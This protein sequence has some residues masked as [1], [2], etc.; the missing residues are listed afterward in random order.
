MT[1]SFQKWNQTHLSVPHLCQREPDQVLSDLLPCQSQKCFS[2]EVLTECEGKIKRIMSLRYP[3]QTTR[4][5]KLPINATKKGSMWPRKEEGKYLSTS[6]NFIISPSTT[7]IT[8]TS[9]RIAYRGIHP[10]MHCTRVRLHQTPTET[11]TVALSFP[12]SPWR[13]FPRTPTCPQTSFGKASLQNLTVLGK[14][15]SQEQC[16]VR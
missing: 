1:G 10:S 11:E 16:K 9:Y 13:R 3:C 14:K 8:T 7:S 6:C 2:N 4:T 5:V 12:M 15:M